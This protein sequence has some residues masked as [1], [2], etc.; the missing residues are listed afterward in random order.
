MNKKHSILILAALML[1][2]GC[3]KYDKNPIVENNR[4]IDTLR[5]ISINWLP[6]VGN[7]FPKGDSAFV[8]AVFESTSGQC[9]E[10]FDARDKN[11]YKVLRAADGL[12][13]IDFLAVVRNNKID[14]KKQIE[15]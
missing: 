10:T 15:R 2:S 1:I 14:L 8:N 9:F 12:P 11:N 6:S 13:D 7:I 5:L 4:Q 3:K